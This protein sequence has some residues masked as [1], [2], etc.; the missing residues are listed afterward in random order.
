MYP[1]PVIFCTGV[2]T[3]G[4]HEVTSM[5]GLK[6]VK[7]LARREA[8]DIAALTGTPVI[9]VVKD[10]TLHVLADMDSVE[11]FEPAPLNYITTIIKINDKWTAKTP[12]K[13]QYDIEEMATNAELPLLLS[14][15]ARQKINVAMACKA[16]GAAHKEFHA[17]FPRG[18]RLSSKIRPGA[19][20]KLAKATVAKLIA[21][22]SVKDLTPELYALG[23]TLI[24]TDVN[25]SK[26]LRSL[27]GGPKIMVG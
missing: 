12:R 1:K 3:G 14:S 8:K 11:K 9:A 20:P 26:Y 4:F 18:M 27:V 10:F 24:G 6:S 13:K 5:D 16:I 25:S 7:A 22:A 17:R 21:G 2:A 15:E 23:N 19:V